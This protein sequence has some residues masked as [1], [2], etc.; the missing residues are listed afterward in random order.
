M[1]YRLHKEL[2][3]KQWQSKLVLMGSAISAWFCG[4]NSDYV[5]RIRQ[6][7]HLMAHE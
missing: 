7:M 4:Y 5:G 6:K 1:R 2:G 3:R